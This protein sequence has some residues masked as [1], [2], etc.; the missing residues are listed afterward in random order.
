MSRNQMSNV[1]VLGAGLAGLA[2]SL[3]LARTG[4]PVVLLEASAETGGCCSNARVSGFTFNNG[5][6][7]VA[8]PSLLRR[9]FRR[10]GLD[11]DAEVPLVSIGRPHETCLDDGTVVRLSN[12]ATSC[13]EGARAQ[14][15][16]AILRRGLDALQQ[17]WGPVYR[18]LIDEVVP[19]EPSLPRTVCR[20]WRYL[21][22]MGGTIDK[23]IA[24]HFP[25][26]GIQAAVASTLLYTGMPPDRLPATQII[27]LLAL[28]EEGFHLPRGGMG[29]ISAALCRELQRHPVSIRCGEPV[30]RL[31]VLDGAIRGVELAS[32]E[33][34]AADRVI[35][36]CSGFELVDR[37]LPREAVPPGLARKARKTPMSH[38]AISIQLGCSGAGLPDAFIVNH[39]PPMHEQGLMHVAGPGVPRWL[40]YTNPTRVL[41]DLAPGGKAVIE[42][43]A[44]VSGIAAASEWTQ[45]MTDMAADNHV[46][47]LKSRLPGL[48]I[49]AARVLGP[50]DFVRG[51]HLHEGAL[52]GIAP[53]ATPDKLFPHRTALRGLYLAG[54]TTFPGYG[55]PSAILSGIQAADALAQDAA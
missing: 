2:A 26:P 29:E 16:T 12:A 31:D 50:Q 41:P 38:R 33:R 24:S 23:L 10:L 39:V 36:T 54:Q 34:I 17:H 42:L 9:A 35:V 45:E 14:D 8:A 30:D 46:A 22:R 7:Y 4:R 5:A 55:V 11:F 20:L 15:R 32:G 37:L 3:S 53:G 43:F 44:P 13:V 51:R 6:L 19:F 21:P 40:A 1:V 52:Y 25:D 49:E 27:G 18:A 28:L 48:A 47:A